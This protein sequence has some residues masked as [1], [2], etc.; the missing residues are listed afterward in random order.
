[1]YK[2]VKITTEREGKVLGVAGG[3]Y[4]VIFACLSAILNQLFIDLHP[5]YID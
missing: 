1:M 4:R 5:L 3:N 2:E